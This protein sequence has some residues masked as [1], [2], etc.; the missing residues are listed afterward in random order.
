MYHSIVIDAS[1]Q[2]LQ[3]VTFFAI[4]G[5]IFKV[6]WT[7]NIIEVESSENREQKTKHK[8][9]SNC[10]NTKRQ[11]R[12]FKILNKALYVH[13]WGNICKFLLA[14]NKHWNVKNGRFWGFYFNYRSILAFCEN[15]LHWLLWWAC[16]P[17]CG[18]FHWHA[19]GQTL[20]SQIVVPRC[21]KFWH[22][23]PLKK[24]CVYLQSSENISDDNKITTV[25]CSHHR[26]WNRWRWRGIR[27]YEIFLNHD[28]CNRLGDRP[29]R[30]NIWP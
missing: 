19:W 5:I 2:S 20:E 4:A 11:T 22:L 17:L 1:C 13:H 9:I 21:W 12:I 8:N 27:G 10:S 16:H 15:S 6:K 25:S 24:C 18:H 23:F 30:S 7:L 3:E 28:W 26:R 14:E 29:Q